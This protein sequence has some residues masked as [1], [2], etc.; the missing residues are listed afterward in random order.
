MI[1]FDAVTKRY[2]DGTVAVG[3]LSMDM[4]DGEITVLVG[5]SGCGKTT[6]LR[7]VNRMIEPTAGSIQINGRDVM[8]MPAH[9]LRRGIGYV[10]QQVGLF[11]HRRVLDN[12][13]TVLRLL[14]WDKRKAETRAAKLLELVGLPQ[15]MAKRYPSQL[16]GG[17]RST[18]RA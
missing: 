7:T 4:L 10:I 11:P 16:S 1:R 18:P 15:T 14:G 9:E 8:S 2:A 5:P 3:D 12:I 17:R 13:T 6:T